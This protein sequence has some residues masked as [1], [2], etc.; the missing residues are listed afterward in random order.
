MQKLELKQIQ[1][2]EKCQKKHGDKYDYSKSVYINN[3]TPVIIICKIHGEFAQSPGSHYN[4][5]RGCPY[6]ANNIK[7]SIGQVINEFKKVHGEKYDYS[8]VNYISSNLNVIIICPIHGEFNQRASVHQNGGGCPYCA[9]NVA[10]TENQIINDFKKVH[11][12][13]YDYSLVEYKGRRNKVKII[14]CIHGVFEQ[15][16]QDHLRGSGCVKCSLLKRNRKT[17][18]EIIINFKKIHKDNYDYSKVQYEGSNK[19]KVIIICKKHGEFKQNPHNHISGNGCPKCAKNQNLTQ[20]EFEERANKMHNNKYDYSKANFKNVSSKVII[21]CPKH[22]EFEQLATNHIHNY[23][24]CPKCKLSKGEIKVMNFLEQNKIEYN[25]EKTFKDC[26]NKK[27]LP[28]DFYLPK[29]N[30][31]I[32]F[33]GKQHYEKENFF[34]G[35]T[36]LEYTKNNDKIKKEFC[37]KNGIKLIRI[38]YNKNIDEI[39]NKYLLN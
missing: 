34:G 4:G 32:E 33:Q 39:L 16:P 36:A 14:C 37:K 29:H 18:E 8:K 10:K 17:T 2:I 26:K 12:D 24:G 9:N 22:G 21:I 15:S 38:K 1:F 3:S 31:C 7:K 6:C 20:E 23:N 25:I 11:G 30:I 28:F 5:G 35:E 13:K 19:R 27:A